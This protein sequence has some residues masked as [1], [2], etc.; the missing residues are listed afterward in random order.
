LLVT[1]RIGQATRLPHW[2]VWLGAAA[3]VLP[4][5]SLLPYT[6]SGTE[7]ARARNSLVL[8]AD[9]DA[10]V[11]WTPPQVPAGFLVDTGPA[12]PVFVEVAQRL[13]LAEM[14]TD[15]DRAVAISRHLLGSSP[16]LPGGATQAD[17]RTTYRRIVTN[18]GGYCVDFV[19]AFSAI[20]GAAGMPM[21]SWAFSFD[22]FGGHGHILPEIWNRQAR[23]WQMV[24][25]FN[26]AYFTIADKPLS[27]RAFRAALL[28]GR[29]MRMN[30]LDPAARPG[31][32]H[33]EKAWDY[34]RRGLPEWYLWWGNNPFTYDQAFSVRVLSPLSR[35]L[36]QLGAMLQG[37]HP[38]IHVLAT[39][40][41][42]P[43]RDALRGVRLHLWVVVAS[44]VAGL[45][46]VVAALVQSR[47][48]HRRP[49][50][51]AVGV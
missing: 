20:A 40:D 12:E 38:H 3:I 18:G 10:N 27:A 6:V 35:P 14:P 46:L 30:R 17:L 45:I 37:V 26:N 39:A 43:Q 41:N 22:G 48:K 29:P 9:A 31:Y 28:A 21:R 15:W 36:A 34:Y 44:V 19:Q 13:H 16:T 42:L 2:A 24:D 8:D 11:D 51:G 1:R 23:E 7:A 32:I 49:M 33:E 50:H 5:L 25:L 4:L 47:M